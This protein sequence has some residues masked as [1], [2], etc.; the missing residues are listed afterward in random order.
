MK[1]TPDPAAGASHRKASAAGSCTPPAK[2]ASDLSAA[3]RQLL[4]GGTRHLDSAG[5]RDALRDLYEFWLT[6]K[7]TEIGVT[8][9]SGFAI[10][11]TGGLGRGE[12][13]PYS[14]LDLT[15]V[16]D[17]MPD[18]VVGR[19]AESLW[20]P[21]WDANIRLD[22]SVR[23][24]P[25]ALKVASEDI[26]AGLAM[27]EARHIAGDAELSGLLIGGARR[28]WRTGI[29]SRYEQLVEETRCPLGAQRPDRASRRTRPQERTRWAPRRPTPQRPGD[30]PTGRRLS[31]RISGVADRITRR[32]APG[33]VECAHRVAPGVGPGP[34]PG[35][36]PVRR[37]DRSGAADRRPLRPGPDP[38][39]RRPHH[40]L[41]RRLRIAHRG[42][43][44]AAPGFVRVT[45]ARA[46]AARRGGTGVQRR[47]HPGPRRPPRA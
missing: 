25:E 43:C 7:A 33:V 17:N 9:T 32:R 18:D 15:L 42:Q 37:R 46:H 35:D 36:G 19:I 4:N 23:T 16:H 28:Q 44:V 22:H 39:R 13:A 6:T 24:V 27:L 10:V 20:Y 29:A 38:L 30:R 40:Q 47:G 11:A 34:R 14:D 5:L 26:A 1:T 8:A 3:V 2:A 12:L 31:E 41:L 21:L 45:P